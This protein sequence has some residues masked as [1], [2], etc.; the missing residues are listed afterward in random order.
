MG[1]QECYTLMQYIINKNQ[2]G[3]FSPADFNKV[4][5]IAQKSYLDYLLGEYQKYQIKR[6][7]AVVEFGQNE[8]V[9]ES[10][11]PLIYGTQLR[12]PPNGGCPTPND[13]EYTDS[14]WAVYGTYGIYN[15]IRFVQQDR[16]DSY[17]NSTI[18]PIRQNPIY[19]INHEGFLFFPQDIGLANLSYVRTPPSIVYATVNDS[20]NRPVYDPFNS[21]DP[22][23]SNTD[24]FQV[25]VRALMLVGCNLQLNNVMQLANEVKNNGQ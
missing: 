21:V 25:I 20:N 6:P 19:L 3:F 22:V 14:M 2:Q 10:I 17:V 12:I 23:W 5:N 7:V 18:D 15:R 1:V 16:L 13:Y 9:R 4:I 24:I 8:R 11:S